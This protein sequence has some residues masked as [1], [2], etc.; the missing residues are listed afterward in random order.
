MS[1]LFLP[2]GAMRAATSLDMLYPR[3]LPKL[4]EQYL[5]GT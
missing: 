3:Q 2:N 4:V 5:G 1:L